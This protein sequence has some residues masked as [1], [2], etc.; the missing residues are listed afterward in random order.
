MVL[1]MIFSIMLGTST[2][3]LV[4]SMWISGVGFASM[5]YFA[6]DF[7]MV[8]YAAKQSHA[9]AGTTFGVFNMLSNVG[10]FLSPIIIGYILDS[11]GNFLLGF[12]S[13]G[14]I[15]IIGVVGA[16]LLRADR[17]ALI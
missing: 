3:G 8:P 12:S 15:G 5:L 2:S 13:I 4:A 14:C 10:S 1:A 17:K 9:V 7:S 6:A 11:T 16:I